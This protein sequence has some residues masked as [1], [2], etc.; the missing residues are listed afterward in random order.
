M[1]V[2]ASS[3]QSE[4]TIELFGQADGYVAIGFSDDQQMVHTL[5]HS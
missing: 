4:Y 1:A 5:S 3:N 2:Q